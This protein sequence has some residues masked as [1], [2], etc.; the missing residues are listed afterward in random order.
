[1]KTYHTILMDPPWNFKTYSKKGQGRSAEKHYP[2]SALERI[3]STPPPAEDNCALFMWVTDPFL[4]KGLAV[5]RSWG[6]TYK[7]VAFTWVKIIKNPSILAKDSYPMGMGYWTRSNPEMCLLGTKGKPKRLS[8]SVRQLIVAPRREH[9]RKPDEIYERIEYLVGGP[10]LEM[11]S[12]TDRTGWDA[13][14]NQTGRW[15]A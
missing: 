5:L 7:T 1:M 15:V 4:E 8:A 10:Y 3:I 12:R 6:F 9:S 2:C 13:F 14:G 11:Y